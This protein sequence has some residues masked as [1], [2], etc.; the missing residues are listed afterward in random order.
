[1]DSSLMFDGQELI[2]SR[3]AAEI[4]KYKQDY[5]GQLCRLGQIDCRR[6]GTSWYVSV[7]SV[8]RH[9][10][11]AKGRLVA[12]IV[13]RKTPAPAK[14]SFVSLSGK[15]YISSHLAAAV[16]GYAQDYVGQLARQGMLPAQME[17]NRWYVEREALLRHKKEKDEL[18]AAV[19]VG[20]TG[21]RRPVDVAASDLEQATGDLI[22]F[23]RPVQESLP[24]DLLPSPLRTVIPTSTTEAPEGLISLEEDD[25]GQ[26]AASVHHDA[27]FVM[28]V[29]GTSSRGKLSTRRIGLGAALAGTGAL[30]LAF[31]LIADIPESAT[32][33]NLASTN[34]GV[35]LPVMN[36]SVS[37]PFAENFTATV[38][39]FLDAVFADHLQSDQ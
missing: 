37:F 12:G 8:E 34:L 14:E 21:V 11:E 36:R 17:G 26:S 24:P 6:V 13:T 25:L 19:Q 32:K 30:V 16:T 22:P 9:K 29:S 35:S 28:R 1:M 7:A 39:T 15:E 2:S 23:F 5:I 27:P 31:F 18:L 3:R 33:A 38:S 10:K 4:T 20:S